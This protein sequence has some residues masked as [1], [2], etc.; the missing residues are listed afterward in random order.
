MILH[1][2]LSLT[3]DTDSTE[4]L[5]FT[6]SPQGH[7]KAQAGDLQ[8]LPSVGTR[9]QLAAF[10][11]SDQCKQG[12]GWRHSLNR[13][14][15]HPTIRGPMVPAVTLW[16]YQADSLSGAALT[17]TVPDSHWI[18]RHALQIQHARTRDAHF[19]LGLK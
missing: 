1:G 4:G 18:L 7:G 9:R 13:C 5:G 8:A 17:P 14:L 10:H 15:E 12:R 2:P 3:R 11:G 19:H 16:V 6:C